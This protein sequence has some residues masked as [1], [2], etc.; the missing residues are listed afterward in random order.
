MN[1]KEELLERQKS[2]IKSLFKT[3]LSEIEDIKEDFDER[4]RLLQDQL[5]PEHLP[6]LYA[7]NPLTNDR[8][9]R[10]RKRILDVGNDVSRAMDSETERYDVTFVFKQ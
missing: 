8:F 7:A 2:H 9:M 10:I 6:M 5:S 4:Y 1:A 3:L